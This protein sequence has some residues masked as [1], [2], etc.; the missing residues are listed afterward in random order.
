[1][2]TTGLGLQHGPWGK[3]LQLV[4]SCPLP[5]H[6]AGELSAGSPWLLCSVH[7]PF[8]SPQAPKCV[9]HRDRQML[10]D[11]PKVIEWSWAI[12]SLYHGA[13]RREGRRG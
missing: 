4:P 7:C 12:P 2:A 6:C 9:C 1:M 10:T 8:L 5:G 13:S 3:G 11:L